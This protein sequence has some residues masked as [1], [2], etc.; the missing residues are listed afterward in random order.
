VVRAQR[1]TWDENGFPVFGRPV[2]TG[3]AMAV[4][5]NRLV[6]GAPLGAPLSLVGER[7]GAVVTVREAAATVVHDA[8]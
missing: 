1:F 5:S 3:R 8:A 2:A 6:P 4:P 7:P